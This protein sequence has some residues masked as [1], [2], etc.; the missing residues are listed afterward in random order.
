LKGFKLV[1]YMHYARKVVC[2]R[3]V[4]SSRRKIKI[5]LVRS[6]KTPVRA[7]SQML[8]VDEIDDE[9][10]AHNQLEVLYAK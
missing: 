4:M 9:L 6:P 7:G 3:G 10:K 2:A 8:V 1:E 5:M